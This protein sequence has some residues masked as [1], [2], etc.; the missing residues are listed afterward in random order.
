MATSSLLKTSLHNSIADGLYTEIITNYSRYYYFLGRT[1]T[2][3]DELTPPEPVDS[4]DYELKTRNEIITMKVIKPTDVSYVVL[5]HNWL[6]GTVYDQFDDQYCTEVQGVNLTD[7]GNSYAT[8]PNVYIGS[9]GSV[10][11]QAETPVVYGTMLKTAADKVYVVTNTGVTGTTAPTFTDEDLNGTATLMFIDHSDG[12]GSGATAEA[13]V[14]DNAVVDI[15]LLHRGLGYTSSPTVTI[16]GGNGGGA[17]ASG[18]I[19]KAPSGTQ[20][21]ENAIFYVVTDEYNVYQCIDNNYGS[22]SIVKPTGT[23]YDSIRASDGYLWKFLFSIP[24]ALR[25]KFL[26]DVYMPVVTALR[27]QF[28]SAGTLKIIRINQVGSGYSSGSITVQG[29]GYATGESIYL[30]GYTINSGGSDYVSPTITI[31]PPV[32]AANTWLD[33][34]EVLAGQYIQYNNNIYKIAVAGTTGATAPTHRSGYAANGTAIFE[35]IGTTATAELVVVDGEITGLTLFGMIK[36]IELLDGGSGY[37]NQ[38]IIILFH[39]ILFARWPE[40]S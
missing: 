10:N 20:K 22:S 2:W 26:T 28:Y 36:K 31:D 6:S 24:I 14:A 34:Q 23:S 17:Q 15:T 19:T 3:E 39:L 8:T 33:D 35:Y 9:E 12:N 16:I 29:D 40:S 25:N 5:R 37:I 1:L 21:L 38:K 13:I 11:W 30:T 32:N 7:G 4:Y 27:E 18:V